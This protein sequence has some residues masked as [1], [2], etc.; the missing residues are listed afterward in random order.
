M[1]SQFDDVDG[2][3]DQ[4]AD[5]FLFRYRFIS[6]NQPRRERLL[7]ARACAGRIAPSGTGAE[8]MPSHI[9]NKSYGFGNPRYF[10]KLSPNYQKTV[11]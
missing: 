6:G 11:F 7:A 3:F 4:S 10:Q 5:S 2:L 8:S 9:I 1:M